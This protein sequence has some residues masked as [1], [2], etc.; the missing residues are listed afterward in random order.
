MI[1]NVWE[2]CKRWYFLEEE[3]AINAGFKKGEWGE[4]EKPVLRQTIYVNNEYYLLAQD[5]PITVGYTQD[6][7]DDKI[8]KEAL[9]KLSL[10]ERR[11][12]G[13]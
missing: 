2:V 10:D 5:H 9:D 3:D 7:F 12:L 8:R 13:I 4:N 1:T 6:I 11:V